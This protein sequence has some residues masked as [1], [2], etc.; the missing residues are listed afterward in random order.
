MAVASNYLQFSSKRIKQ[1]TNAF[2]KEC[3][4]YDA[5]WNGTQTKIN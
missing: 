1:D 3:L 5:K 2:G 4:R